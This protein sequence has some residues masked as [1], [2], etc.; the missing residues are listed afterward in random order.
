MESQSRDILGHL[1]VFRQEELRTV[2]LWPEMEKL[3]QCWEKRRGGNWHAIDVH[4]ICCLRASQKRQW[5]YQRKHMP[6]NKTEG[7]EGNID[8]G[9]GSAGVH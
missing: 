3:N 1:W 2:R 4:V 8:K 6:I 5:T 7:T 9:R